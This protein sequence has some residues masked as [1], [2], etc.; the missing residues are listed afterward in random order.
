MRRNAIISG[1]LDAFALTAL[2]VY[3]VFNPLIMNPSPKA[4]FLIIAL[5]H[6]SG[7]VVIALTEEGE[8]TSIGSTVFDHESQGTSYLES[9]ELVKHRI[10]FLIVL[11]QDRWHRIW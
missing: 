7:G 3:P 4:R 2:L 6:E 1:Q 8:K 9:Y 11:R 10:P 5:R